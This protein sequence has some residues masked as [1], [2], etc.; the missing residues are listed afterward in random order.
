MH[1]NMESIYVFARLAERKRGGY[2]TND[3]VIGVKT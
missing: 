1:H 3:S 2:A